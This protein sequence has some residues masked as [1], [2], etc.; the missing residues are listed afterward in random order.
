MCLAWREGVRPHADELAELF[1]VIDSGAI[2][3]V[4]RRPIL[5]QW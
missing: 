1:M 5:Q 2:F 3:L 4:D